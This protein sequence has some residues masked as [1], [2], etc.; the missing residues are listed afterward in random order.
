MCVCGSEYICVCVPARAREGVLVFVFAVGRECVLF[1]LA[2]T[3]Q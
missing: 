2:P 3:Y 1:F